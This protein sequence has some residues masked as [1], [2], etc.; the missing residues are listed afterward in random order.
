MSARPIQQHTY[1]RMDFDMTLILTNSFYHLLVDIPSDV[2][3]IINMN[4]M[5]ISDYIFRTFPAFHYEDRSVK[6]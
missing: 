4:V 3:T 6:F 1:G 2:S 5:Y